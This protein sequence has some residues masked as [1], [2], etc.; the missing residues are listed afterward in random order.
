MP[1]TLLYHCNCCR[2]TFPSAIRP[3]RCP[4]CGKVLT[5]MG[6]HAIRPASWQEAEEYLLLQQEFRAEE[7]RERELPIAAG[8]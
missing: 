3:G 6:R 7:R 1:D 2:Y 8:L 4:D 5:A